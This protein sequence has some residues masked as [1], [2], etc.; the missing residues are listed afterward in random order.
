[1]VVA[2]GRLTLRNRWVSDVGACGAVG[3]R[4]IAL[5]RC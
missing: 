2:K 1:M 5:G 4:G 3:R